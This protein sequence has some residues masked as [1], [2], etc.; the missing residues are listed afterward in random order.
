MRID[1]EDAQLRRNSFPFRLKA[2]VFIPAG[3]RPCTINSTNWKHFI[4]FDVPTSKLIIE[5]V[6]FYINHEARKKLF[7]EAG[8]M[9]VKDSI[10]AKADRIAASCEIACYM[11]L[12]KEELLTNKSQLVRD[13]VTHTHN[14]CKAEAK[15]LFS[16]YKKFPE[17]LPHLSERISNSINSLKDAILT[18]LDELE[19]GDPVLEELLPLVK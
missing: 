9:I 19:L 11:L 12:S 13:V 3:G 7:K 8:V 17:D 10:V 15:L 18:E 5:C 14:L 4:D 2:D 1:S 16:T 6:H